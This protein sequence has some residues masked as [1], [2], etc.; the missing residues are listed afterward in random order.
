MLTKLLTTAI[1][2][3][4]LIILFWPAHATAQED[5]F[6]AIGCKKRL[7]VMRNMLEEECA[8]LVTGIKASQSCSDT[9]DKLGAVSKDKCIATCP[10]CKQIL[11]LVTDLAQRCGN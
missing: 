6:G 1:T 11:Q 4:L 8:E 3:Q 10:T 2:L 5:R 9:C 7:E